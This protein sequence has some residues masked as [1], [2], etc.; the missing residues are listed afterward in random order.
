MYCEEPIRT[1]LDKLASREPIPGGGSA[2]ALAGSIGS[3]LLGKVANFTMGKE[4]YKSV[5]PEMKDILGKL[6]KMRKD[7]NTL[8][9]KDSVAYIKVSKV[10]K[11]P[12]GEE[13]K[14][15]LEPALKEAMEV[16]LEV[17]KISHE[18][19]KLSIPLLERGNVNLITDVGD[20]AIM[21]EAAFKAALLN[22]DINLKSIKDEKFI[23]KTKE[24]LKPMGK[25]IEDCKVKVLKK[26]EEYLRS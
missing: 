6:E 13:R 16:P 4:K 20:G 7:L 2:S 17:C 18:A 8:I 9:S 22:V 14:K 26:V 19:I 25:D 24:A 23:T 12:K 10:F 1:Y 3:A 5:E 21:L 15:A 11:M